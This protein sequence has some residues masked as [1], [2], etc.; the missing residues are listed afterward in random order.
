M[1]WVVHCGVLARQQSPKASPAQA[2]EWFAPEV[3]LSRAAPTMTDPGGWRGVLRS[4]DRPLASTQL[5]RARAAR[6]TS[7]ANCDHDCLPPRPVMLITIR[8]RITAAFC[9]LPTRPTYGCAHTP[10]SPARHPAD[11]LKHRRLWPSHLSRLNDDPK[12][13]LPENLGSVSKA[14]IAD[15]AALQIRPPTQSLRPSGDRSQNNP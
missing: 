4:A 8:T 9:R 15:S 6:R 7:A 14:L 13:S 2:R 5:L 1:H 10:L 12:S 3:R 11:A